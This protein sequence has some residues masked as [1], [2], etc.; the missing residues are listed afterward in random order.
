MH[1]ALH[2]EHALLRSHSHR[3]DSRDAPLFAEM[4]RVPPHKACMC[5]AAQAR[6]RGTRHSALGSA[7]RR[8]V[9]GKARQS[10]WTPLLRYACCARALSQSRWESV[11]RA[12]RCVGWL[13]WRSTHSARR[14]APVRPQRS[15]DPPCMTAE[16]PRTC[17]PC[18]RGVSTLVWR[19]FT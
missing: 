16:A 11:L 15:L 12:L 6:R 2:E 13:W 5:A 3:A 4:R 19:D 7:E 18:W 17:A 8:N 9:D 14:G 10:D 1:S